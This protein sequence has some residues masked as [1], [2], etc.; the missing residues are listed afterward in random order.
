[1]TTKIRLKKFGLLPRRIRLRLKARQETKTIKKYFKQCNWQPKRG[2]LF[3]P[4]MHASYPRPTLEDSYSSVPKY[5]GSPMEYQGSIMKFGSIME[6]FENSVDAALDEI[7]KS[8]AKLPEKDREVQARILWKEQRHQ[9]KKPTENE[10]YYPGFGL[11][12]AKDIASES[13]LDDFENLMKSR[14]KRSKHVLD[15]CE[16]S[17]RQARE[18]RDK[19]GETG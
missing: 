19:A 10:F 1:M 13:E 8:V 16:N 6:D 14:D 11:V 15:M 5:H 18:A 2:P 4:E 17:L 3:D 12:T 9:Y 7:E